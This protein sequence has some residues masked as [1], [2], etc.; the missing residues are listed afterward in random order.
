MRGAV[1]VLVKTPGLSPV[2]TRLAATIGHQRAEQFFLLAK[3]AMA[4]VLA[5]ARAV[6]TAVDV[7]LSTYWAIGEVQGVKHPL[8]QTKGM[9]C[10]HTGEGGLGER[11]CHVYNTLLAKHDFVVL[12]GM[13]SPQNTAAKLLA[14][15]QQLRAPDSLVFGPVYDGGF[16][17]LG[18]NKP[19][20]LEQ[21]LAVTYSAD[22]TLEKLVAQMTQ[23]VERI[24]Y[25]PT[26]TDVDTQPDLAAI[27]QE[28]PVEP[29][30][31]QAAVVEWIHQADSLY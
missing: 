23:P 29:L 4:A 9:A 22:D 30:P 17:L 11:M 25:L 31:A 8:W 10:M 19:I 13:D 7:E 6:G 28:M 27:C 24:H 14:A 12:L 16:Y 20:A 2:K 18:G 26:L 15:A 21:W 5:D 1:A 3:D